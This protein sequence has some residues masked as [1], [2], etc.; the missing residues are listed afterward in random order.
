M[1]KKFLIFCLFMFLLIIVGSVGGEI[2]NY[3]NV[4]VRGNTFAILVH[5]VYYQLSGALIM[6][7]IQFLIDEK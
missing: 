7:F 5:S 1:E 2:D 6:L 4:Q 3:L